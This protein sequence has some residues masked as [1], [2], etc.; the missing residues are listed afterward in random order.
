[1]IRNH[2]DLAVWR[3][4]MRIAED[5]YR[6]SARL[7]LDERFGLKLQLRRAAASIAANI[8]EGAGRGSR[9]EF[10]RYVS[11]ARGSVCELETHLLLCERL[12]FLTVDAELHECVDRLRLMLSK[13]RSTLAQS[14]H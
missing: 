11:I 7:P 4:G 8:A 14:A 3:E 1:M 5:V 6:I 2:K 9:I 12:G 10:A 13:L